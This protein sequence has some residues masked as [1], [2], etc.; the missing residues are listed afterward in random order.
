MS[1]PEQ[2]PERPA[3][4]G[5]RQA[6]KRDRWLGVAL[7]L[8]THL[9]FLLALFWTL[10]PPPSPPDPAPMT[11]TLVDWQPPAP[12]ATPLAAAAPAKVPPPPPPPRIAARPA[13]APPDV[14]SIP[15]AKVA[16][17]ESGSAL[18]EAELAGATTA[19]SGPAGRPC[20]MPRRI[21]SALRKDPLVQAAVAGSSAK[22]IMV[23][24]GDW[25]RSDG[26]DGKGLAAVREA[27]MWEVAFA[28]AACRAEPVR[29]LILVS[30][31][32]AP[33]STRLAVGSGEWRWSDLL[34][35]PGGIPDEPASKP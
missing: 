34:R 3:A 8:A 22:A 35:P 6:A 11:V 13:Q 9:A 12:K 25:V 7:S 26:E 23:W 31:N 30:V 19:D 15:A 32:A 14:V 21:Q 27:I 16:S 24:N 18:T 2:N 28:P 29:G 1:G 10:A 4:Q 17:A 20:D 33:G 5:R